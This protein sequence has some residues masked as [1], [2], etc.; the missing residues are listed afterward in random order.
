MSLIEAISKRN[1]KL[2]ARILENETVSDEELLNAL[3]FAFEKKFIELLFLF[4]PFR[5][6]WDFLI[7]YAVKIKNFSLYLQLIEFSNYDPMFEL[8]E[9]HIRILKNQPFDLNDVNKQDITGISPVHLL[10]WKG[11]MKEQNPEEEYVRDKFG[12]LPYEFKI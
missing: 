5:S 6:T 2:V 1:A 3:Q 12:R 11:L 10:F 8:S 4:I 9:T 7:Y